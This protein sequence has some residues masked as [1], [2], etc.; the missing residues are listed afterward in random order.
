MTT[1]GL[2]T[3][4]IYVPGIASLKEKRGVVKPL[5]ARLRK[6]FNVSVAE[7]EDQDQWGHAVI[8]VAAVSPSPDYVHGLLTR[9]AECVTEWR[10]D[11]ELVDYRIEIL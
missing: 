5:I 3:L 6:E 7:V 2:L 1:V 8:A 10:L 9:V 11:A 4:E